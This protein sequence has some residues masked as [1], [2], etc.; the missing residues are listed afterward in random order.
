MHLFKFSFR[1]ILLLFFCLG[2]STTIG[3]Q[4][5]GLVLDSETMLPIPFASIHTKGV[6]VRGTMSNDEGVFAIEFEYDTLYFSHINYELKKLP[7]RKSKNDTILMNPISHAISGI[8]II[9]KNTKWVENILRDVV[10]NR[11]KNYQQK[12]VPLD[13]TFSLQSLSDSSGYAF[14]S[15]GKI[16]S[17]EYSEKEGFK[18]CPT[19]NIIKYK[20]KTAGPDFMQL[21]RSVYEDFINDFDNGFIKKHRFTQTSFIDEENENIVQFSFELRKGEGNSGY[22][23]VDTLNKVITEFE[24]ISGTDYNI[25][26]NTSFFTRTIASSRGF[27]Y[28]IWRTVVYGQ[29]SL[30]DESYQ[31][32]DSRYQ[33]YRQSKARGEKDLF[34]TNI[35]SRLTMKIP[36]ENNG[37]ADECD[38]LKL[39]TPRSITIIMGKETRLA[40]EALDNVVVEYQLF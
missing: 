12:E 34:F 37:I 2:L 5:N 16:I 20:D 7:N 40:E 21:R 36:N 13:Y 25:K 3:A 31:L 17:P 15:S 4:T 22:V 10:N 11:S 26:S 1:E 27:E 24:Q 29:F 39:P 19:R 38:W 32:T 30:I 18:I 6:N 14:E 35:E 9:A 28:T 23:M 33:L 8:V